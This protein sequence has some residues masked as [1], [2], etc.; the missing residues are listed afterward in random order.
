M[1]AIN[2]APLTLTSLP[3]DII[4]KIIRLDGVSAGNERLVRAFLFREFIA[5]EAKQHMKDMYSDFTHLEFACW[6]VS[7]ISE[8]VTCSRV[9]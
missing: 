5:P 1:A 3:A 2:N 4:R 9:R 8:A 7:S 6:R